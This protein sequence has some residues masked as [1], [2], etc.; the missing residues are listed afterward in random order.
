MKL[1]RLVRGALATVLMLAVGATGACRHTA[2]T[3]ARPKPA[4]VSFN[5]QIEVG[6]NHYSIEGFIAR[7]GSPGRLPALLVLTAGEGNARRCIEQSPGLVPI[8]K[9]EACI[10]I[11]GYGKTSGPSRF[12]GPQA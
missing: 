7:S 12:C 11:P 8:G 2:K 5:F 1:P 9:L 6:A 3:E 10:S 4:F